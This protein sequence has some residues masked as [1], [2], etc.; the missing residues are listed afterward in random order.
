MALKG[1]VRDSA[2]IGVGKR[3]ARRP[4]MPA[5]KGGRGAVAPAF[6]AEQNPAKWLLQ[7]LQEGLRGE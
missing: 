4:K 5:K 6:Y 3:L 7:G 2:L 1:L